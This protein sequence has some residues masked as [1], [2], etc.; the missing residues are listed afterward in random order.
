MLVIRLQRVG[1]LKQPSYRLVIN[2]KT[3][4]VQG[5]S[6]EILGI[7]NP[8]RRPKLIELKKERINFWLSKGAQLSNTV[9]NLLLNQGVISGEKKK[10]SVSL[11]K[12]RLQKISAKKAGALKKAETP[13]TPA[14]T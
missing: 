5:K 13:A 8:V 7:Y 6:L 3:R 1:K 9:N 10:K 2:E 12:K 4:D 14:T 11:S